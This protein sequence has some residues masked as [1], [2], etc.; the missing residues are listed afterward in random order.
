MERR[1][2]L[3][4]S[5]IAL[6]VGIVASGA[7]S[8]ATRYIEF[9]VLAIA[10]AVLLLVAYLLPRVTS[11]LELERIEVPRM[12]QRGSSA[13]IALSAEADGLVPAVRIIDQLAGVLV[14]IDLPQIT[15]TQSVV[16]RYRIQAVRRGVHQLGPLLEERSDPFGLV[17]RTTRHD[18]TSELLVHPMLHRLNIVT[19]GTRQRQRMNVRPRI[20]DDPLADFRALREYQYGDDP[21][22]IH[23]ASSAR[24]GSLV[25]R[26][27]FE[28]RRAV[29][30][31]VLDTME[32]T[33]SAGLFEEAVEIAASL[34]IDAI[35]EN[36][37][38]VC[39]TRDVRAPGRTDAIS[40]GEVLELFTRV[41]RTTSEL[42]VPASHVRPQGTDAD[43]I[44]LVAGSGSPLITG[45][46]ANPWVRPRL[47]VVRLA[48]R[49]DAAERMGVPSVT[50]RTAADFV[51]RWKTGAVA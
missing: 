15:A 49:Q 18:V 37:M 42:T 26:D 6:I 30:M 3:T 1:T 19:E 10:G 27:H 34:A 47:V 11:A 5:G 40:Y 17:V 39:R 13:A 7:L 4:S 20:S 23:W 24:V 12:I 8:I 35:N 43:Q 9:G 36:V 50:V 44:F 41:G 22:L 14:P 2:Q 32:S 28:L 33:I 16:V 21:R 46:Y 38:P 29:R 48:E 51:A 31:V 25:V 45:F